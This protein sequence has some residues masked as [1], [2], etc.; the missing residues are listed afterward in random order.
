MTPQKDST[1]NWTET[2]TEFDEGRACRWR[3]GDGETRTEG[4]LTIGTWQG[5]RGS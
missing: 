2:Q 3:D 4:E 5:L 1:Q